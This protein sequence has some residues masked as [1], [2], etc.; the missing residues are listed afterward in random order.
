[1]FW[2]QKQR[3]TA[4]RGCTPGRLMNVT[5]RTAGI[6]GKIRDARRAKGWTQAVLADRIGVFAR[7]VQRWEAGEPPPLLTVIRLQNLLETTLIEPP[8]NGLEGR[9][10]ELER[11]LA[12]LERRLG[13]D[14]SP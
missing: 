3:S 1:M 6:S 9:V 12:E 5:E 13:A 4:L 10:D 7:T 8:R 14:S 11:R 2:Q